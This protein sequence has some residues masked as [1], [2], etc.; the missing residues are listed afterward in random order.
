MLFKIISGVQIKIT[1]RMNSMERMLELIRFYSLGDTY[2][3]EVDF[4]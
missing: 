1:K 2:D 3:R 4:I